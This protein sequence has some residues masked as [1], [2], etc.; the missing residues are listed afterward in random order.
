MFHLVNLSEQVHQRDLLEAVAHSRSSRF[1]ASFSYRNDF[2]FIGLS[3]HS[4]RC[5]HLPAKHKAQRKKKWPLCPYFRLASTWTTSELISV[6]LLLLLLLLL[7][8]SCNHYCGWC[9]SLGWSHFPIINTS[10]TSS[11]S[12]IGIVLGLLFSWLFCC[13]W[14]LKLM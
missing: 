2:A 9:Y 8:L 10:S 7:L 14:H 11:T 12:W 5:P 6:V 1:L 4:Y 13:I 3:G